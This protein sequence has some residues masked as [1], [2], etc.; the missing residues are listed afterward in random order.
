MTTGAVGRLLLGVAIVLAAIGLILVALD[1]F[2]V[3]RLP[4]DVVWRRENVTVYIPLGLM[5]LLSLLLT[6]ILNLFFRR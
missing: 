6:L 4:G 1:R 5:I 2:G 3:G